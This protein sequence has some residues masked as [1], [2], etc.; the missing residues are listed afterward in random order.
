MG[1]ASEMISTAGH[2]CWTKRSSY[3]GERASRP[4]VR[5]PRWRFT[6]LEKDLLA[7]GHDG[8]LSVRGG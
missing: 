8:S 1:M 3:Q 7:G 6:N 4:G 5:S 2:A